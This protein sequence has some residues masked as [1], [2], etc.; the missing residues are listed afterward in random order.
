MEN[1]ADHR[2]RSPA[3]VEARGVTQIPQGS[4]WVSPMAEGWLPVMAIILLVGGWEVAARAHWISPLFFPPPT[5]VLATLF[6]MTVEGRLGPMVGMTLL[7]LLLGVALGAGSGLALGWVM[8]A[9]RPVRIAI[10]PIVAALHPLPK[11]ALFPIFLV[12][13]GIG[14]S[15]KIALVALTAFFPILLNTLAGARQIDRLYW[16]VAS[17]FGASSWIVVR[18]MIIPGSM[19]LALTGL[20]VALNSALM[21]TIAVEMLSAKVGL[22]AAV[23]LTWQTMRMH[24]LYAILMVIASLGI[25]FTWCVKRLALALTPWQAEDV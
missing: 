4:G 25:A 23:W 21:V 3:G 22:G 12:I 15:S 16:E 14:E 2:S 6:E 20:R 17:S 18:R 10:D 8:G 11:L 7:R 5:V 19:P 13:L 24:E 1:L 9:S